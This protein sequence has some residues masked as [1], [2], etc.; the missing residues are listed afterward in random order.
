VSLQEI[1]AQLLTACGQGDLALVKLLLSQ[2]AD[3]DSDDG[4]GFA[5]LHYAA[6][7]SHAE[8]VKVL[9]DAGADLKAQSNKVGWTPL[10][11]AATEGKSLDAAIALL[12][13]GADATLTDSM[14]RTPFDMQ[15]GRAVREYYESRL[16][17]KA[18]S[19]AFASGPADDGDASSK[20]GLSL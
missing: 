12:Y 3:V 20:R 17:A 7:K 5:A 8:V 1:D 14:G 4:A 15:N 16:A 18:I 11:F 2:G 13:A 6:N 19:E 10:H 9:I